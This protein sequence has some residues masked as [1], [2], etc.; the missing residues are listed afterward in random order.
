MSTFQAFTDSIHAVY[1]DFEVEN[2]RA[3]NGEGQFNDILVINHAFI[4]RFA[5]YD[6]SIENL[7]AEMRLLKTIGEVHLTLPNF[8][9]DFYFYREN[10]RMPNSRA[11]TTAAVRLS[12]PNLPNRLV[13]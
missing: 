11:R 10:Q 1:P 5:L 12:T 8:D 13:V 6:A 2:V 9:F 7:A 4:F 3:H